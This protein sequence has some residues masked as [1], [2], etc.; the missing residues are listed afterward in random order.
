MDAQRTPLRKLIHGR[1]L[2]IRGRTEC[3]PTNWECQIYERGDVGI[4]PYSGFS[5]NLFDI[6]RTF[7]VFDGRTECAPTAGCPRILFDICRTGFVFDGRTEC[8]PTAGCP[9]RQSTLPLVTSLTLY[10][11]P[12]LL[13]LN[14][15][16]GYDY[17]N[18]L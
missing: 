16:Y 12:T 13:A 5:H 1:C 11:R 2:G 4:A 10:K 17:R 3:A 7:F 6:C 9:R 14:V 18:T 15:I 8:A